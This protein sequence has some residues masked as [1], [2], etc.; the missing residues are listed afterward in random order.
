MNQ[1]RPVMVLG[2]DAADHE[3]IERW[4]AE[5]KLPTFSKL[6]DRGAYGVLESTAGVFS[7]S[8]WIS[9][10]TGCGP[11]KC[12]SYS[13]YQLSNGTYDVGRIRAEDCKVNSFWALFSGPVVVVD[14]PKIP[15]LSAINGV[16]LVEWGAYDHYSAFASVPTHLSNEISR[17]F[18]SHPFMER[19]FEVALRSR[20]DFALIKKQVLEGVRIKERLNNALVSR[21]KPRLFFSVFGETH[22]AGHALWRFQDSTH[23]GH[24]PGDDLESALLE[25][26]QAID[27][28]IASFLDQLQDDT[29]LMIVSSHGFSIDSMIG[30]DFLA[31]ILVRIGLSVPK[32]ERVNYAYVPYAPALALD[33]TRTRAFCLPTD[34]QGY[35]RINLR[36][37]EP[38]GVVAEAE[39]ESVCCEL[40]NELLELRDCTYGMKIV[41][42]VVRVRDTYHGNHAGA[43]P[44]L[45]VIWKS[46]HVITGVE[47]ARLGVVRRNPDLVAGGGNHR[48]TGFVI[49][50]GR[51]IA[52]GRLAGHVFDIAPTISRLLGEK[53]RPE[54]DGYPLPIPGLEL[55]K[56]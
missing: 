38:Q 10:A 51:D 24:T 8:A 31:E 36:G 1:E 23:P 48:G 29:V 12:A 39:Y 16:Q 19:N 56:D 18:G 50:Y 37:R 40:E 30:E 6:L 17:E 11:G 55:S 14:I 26:Y 46:D 20:R 43:L 34:L 13:R 53:D 35:I 44:D 7:G 32:T 49:V 33:M 25:T 54:W 52:K 27:C 28:A 4:T 2:L 47:S 9:I 41:E 3:L 21:Y 5:G 15:L 45:S 22:A 42:R